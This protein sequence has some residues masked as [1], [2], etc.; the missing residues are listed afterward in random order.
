MLL[1][2]TWP[3]THTLLLC[4]LPRNRGNLVIRTHVAGLQR[5]MLLPSPHPLVLR[6]SSQRSSSLAYWLL[7]Q[8][9]FTWGRSPSQMDIWGWRRPLSTLLL[10]DVRSRARKCTVFFAFIISTLQ[11]PSLAAPQVCLLHPV[12]NFSAVR[13]ADGGVSSL[14]GVIADIAAS[15]KLFSVVLWSMPTQ[16]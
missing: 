15:R 12:S 14:S 1:S 7:S 6:A 8:R 5:F 13:A 11:I 3:P 10:A 16:Q 4:G 2:C 9:V